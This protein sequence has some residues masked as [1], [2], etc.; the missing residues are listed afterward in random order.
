MRGG[1]MC[2]FT[3]VLVGFLGSML[4]FTGAFAACAQ[5]DGNRIPDLD[6]LLVD[7]RQFQN[8]KLARHIEPLRNVYA[9]IASVARI[10]PTLLVCDSSVFNASAGGD[11]QM[12]IIVFHLPMLEFLDGNIDEIAAIMAHEMSHVLLN[13]T[14][15]HKTVYTNLTAWAKA[16]AQQQYRKTGDVDRAIQTG[17]EFRAIER[18]KYTRFTEREADEKGFSLAV[19]LAKFNGEGFKGFARKLSKL[20]PSNR[21][22]YLD[23]HPGWMERLDKAD[24][25]T[26]N[27]Q[28]MDSARVLFTDRNWKVLTAH[29][30]DWLNKIPESGAAWYY[31][32]RILSRNSRNT[33]KITRAFEES[34]ARFVDNTVLGTRSQEDQIEADHVWF[35][36]C[37]AL[38]D[39]GYKYESA[40]CS[41]R[42]SDESAFE[43]FHEQTFGGM[44]IVAG[45]EQSAGNLLVAREPDGSKLFTNDQSIAASRGAYKPVSPAWR[46]I[47]YPGNLL[48]ENR[49]GN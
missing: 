43:K 30:N 9:R 32:G 33:T 29:V 31:Q 48:R 20:P 36:L 42:I 13:H 6:G 39:E 27:Q 40:N 19:T 15:H 8:T 7:V 16:I 26:I 3:L 18:M 28:Y 11:A 38:F 35:Y 21:P 45:P 24:I 34:A 49:K 12:G 2:R 4:H 1:D 25:L 5:I 14:G 23:S 37:L 41:R 44:L 22:R 46:A 10:R 17:L 47:R